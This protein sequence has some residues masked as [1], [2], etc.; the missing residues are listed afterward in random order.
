MRIGL[1]I[2]GD[3]SIRTGGFLYDRKLVEG[4]T[5][6]GYEISTFSLPWRSY[7][8]HLLDN[9]SNRVLEWLAQRKLDILLQDE[10]AH[11]SLFI[12]NSR[13]RRA[14]ATPMISIVHHLRTSESA[15]ILARVF[16]SA[17]ERTYLRSVDGYICNSKTT[18]RSI[19][20]LIHEVNLSS[21]IAYPGRDHIQ[22]GIA[23]AEVETRAHSTTPLQ[24]LFL[25]SIIRRKG[26]LTLI[27]AL[28]GIER[29]LWRLSIAGDDSFDPRFTRSLQR[30]VRQHDLGANITWC[31]AVNN[32]E[33]KELWKLAHVLVV[34]SQYEGFGIVYLEA[35]GHGV[36]PI[37]SNAGGASE[38]ID[39]GGNGYLI[40]ADDVVS[41]RSTIERL[42]V[43]RAHLSALGLAALQRYSR[44][45][46]WRESVREIDTFFKN[47]PFNIV[48]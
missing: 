21:V 13:I 3:L 7:S 36:V 24:L 5:L 26:L 10:L 30:R 34:P 25:G 45:P 43:D 29:D 27:D 14:S 16:Q 37:A 28:A 2:Y 33:L 18:L 15:H 8:S 22:P 23:A 46:T 31:G 4:L 40:E 47:L 48:M 19:Q 12:M 41:L 44:H 11:P 35:M 6:L 20:S 42:C 1:L 38:L 17:I 39:Q 32:R 9:L